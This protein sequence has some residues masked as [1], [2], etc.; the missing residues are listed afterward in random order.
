MAKKFDI[1]FQVLPE[2]EQRETSTLVSFG[3]TSSLGVKGFQMLIN[4]WVKCLLTPR[5][6]DPTDLAYGTDFTKLV[7][8]NISI[9]DSRDV[10][11]VA[12]DQCN[13][14]LFS[15][16]DND[17]TL[18]PSER[19]ASAEIIEFI[20]YPE[21]PGFRVRVELKNQ[22]QERLAVSVPVTTLTE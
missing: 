5:G 6:S 3:T 2:A 8:S 18:T 16:Q 9:A 19:L 1:H 12:V 13:E 17:P 15:F 20:E 7:G 14:Q 11:A 10:V 22:A 21:E 4:Q